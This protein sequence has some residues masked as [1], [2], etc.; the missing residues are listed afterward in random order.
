V[1]AFSLAAARVLL[2]AV[3]WTAAAE[4]LR[5]PDGARQA[6][7]GFG[8]PARLAAAAR[9]LLVLTEL[10]VGGLLVAVR[11]AWWGALGALVLLSAFTLAIA[12]SLLRHRPVNCHCFGQ[13]HARPAGWPA[14]GRNVALGLCAAFV[15]WPIGGA[16]QP[17]VIGALVE[18]ARARPIPTVGFAVVLA[19]IAGLA[20]VAFHLLRQHGRLLLRMDRLEAQLAVA[21]GNGDLASA[22]PVRGLA[23]GTTAPDLELRNLSGAALTTANLWRT[24]RAAVLI[25]A[26]PDCAP[27][28]RM[29]PAVVRW[30]AEHEATLRIAV[31]SRIRWPGG[32]DAGVLLS[33]DVE[34]ADAFQAPG[35][36]AAV[37]VETDGRIG[38]AVVLGPT[39]I[40]RLIVESAAL[41]VSAASPR[42]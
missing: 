13:L 11:S 42:K 26:N 15:L 32:G 27:C 38:S 8:V 40:E 36:P 7:V 28:E 37:R 30:Q 20:W 31:I 22:P 14:I 35:T 6:M 33:E 29:L 9:I 17:D 4:K 19:A 1:I 18:T 23:I 21:G 39:S 41:A 5:D 12:V 34:A 10:V 3:F 24:G 16:A 25:F 2:A